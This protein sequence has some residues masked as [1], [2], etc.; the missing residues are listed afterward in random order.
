LGTSIQAERR[1]N[2]SWRVWVLV[3]IVVVSLLYGTWFNFLDSLVYCL[4]LSDFSQICKSIGA[5]FGGNMYYQ[6]WNVFGHLIPSVFAGLRRP[7]DWR[8]YFAGFFASTVVMDS[9]L[10]GV[11]R[12]Y[13]HHTT[14]WT[15]GPG[16][17]HVPTNNFWDWVLYYYNPFGHYLVW[18]SPWPFAPYPT[19]WLI[20]WSLIIR[21]LFAVLLIFWQRGQEKDEQ[22][23]KKQ[24]VSLGIRGDEGEVFREQGFREWIAELLRLSKK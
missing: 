3:P 13:W 21:V 9:P 2:I 24:R 7:K 4:D 11:I 19:A 6:A 8:L 15:G 17:S 20:F 18:D 12:L 16:G 23:W 14:L 10:W 1:W 5:I 22:M